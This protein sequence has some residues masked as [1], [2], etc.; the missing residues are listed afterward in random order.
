[1]TGVQ[2]C[3]LP[4]YLKQPLENA[5]RIVPVRKLGESSL[6]TLTVTY[7]V[8]QHPRNLRGQIVTLWVPFLCSH[9]NLISCAANK[10]PDRGGRRAE[11]VGEE[12]DEVKKQVAAVEQIDFNRLRRDLQTLMEEVDRRL[13]SEFD[14]FS[15]TMWKRL[16]RT[17]DSVILEI[18][19]VRL[20]LNGY[21]TA[22]VAR[23]LG[24]KKQRVAAFL[25]YNTMWQP[26]YASPGLIVG[27]VDCPACGVGIG[28]RCVTTSGKVPVST[29]PAASSTGSR[30]RSGH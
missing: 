24:L 30:R 1:V 8:P 13:A 12:G 5:V 2:T 22:E 16:Q 29:S 21:T 6:H 4:I 18:S 17:V 11:L 20:A 27:T 10:A 7:A 25:A 23:K 19:A 14:A 15:P 28:S 9:P 26:D 3:A